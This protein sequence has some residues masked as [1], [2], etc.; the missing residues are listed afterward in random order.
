MSTTFSPKS[1]KGDDDGGYL[2]NL[3][4]LPDC[5]FGD[6]DME[7]QKLEKPADCAGDVCSRFS[8]FRIDTDFQL[9]PLTIFSVNNNGF[10]TIL[11][12]YLIN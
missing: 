8:Y 11:A 4:H 9:I 3:Q 12:K 10:A 2:S 6:T 5:S 1:L 7:E